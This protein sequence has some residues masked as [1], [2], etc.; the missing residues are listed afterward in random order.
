MNESIY[1]GDVDSGH[2][3]SKT[4][5]FDNAGIG[6]FHVAREDLPLEC[7]TKLMIIHDRHITPTEC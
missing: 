2:S 1:Y 4:E 7:L 5:F 6:V 3:V